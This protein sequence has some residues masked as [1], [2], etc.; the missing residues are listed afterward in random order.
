MC[1]SEAN[2]VMKRGE[3]MG[4]DMLMMVPIF[5]CSKSMLYFFFF[6]G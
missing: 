6:S 1:F 5:I 2:K 3:L 4:I